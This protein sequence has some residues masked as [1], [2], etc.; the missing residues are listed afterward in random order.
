MSGSASGELDQNKSLGRDADGEGAVPKC[1]VCGAERFA[2]CAELDD[3]IASWES[4]A[5]HRIVCFDDVS[6]V[7]V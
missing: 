6:V 5:A 3:L 1:E 2:S 7:G 4:G